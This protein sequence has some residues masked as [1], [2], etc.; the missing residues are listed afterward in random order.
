MQRMRSVANRASSAA[1]KFIGFLL[2]WQ[3]YARRIGVIVGK[4]CRIYRADFGSEP[5]LVRIGDRVTV[6]AGVRFVTHDGAMCLV[7]D[8]RGRRFRFAP[9]SVGDNVFLGVNS[10]ILPGVCIGNNCIVGAGAV[11]TKS[12]PDNSVVVGVPGRVIGRFD[13]FFKAAMISCPSE[14]DLA[15]MVGLSYRE[16]VAECIRLQGGGKHGC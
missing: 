8:E 4:G 10:T 11:V 9:I 1:L 13:E 6:T 3:W 7:V 14:K 15:N 5:F 12:V 16:W 2:G